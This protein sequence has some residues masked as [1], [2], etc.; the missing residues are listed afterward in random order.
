MEQILNFFKAFIVSFSNFGT[1]FFNTKIFDVGGVSF[2]PYEAL[3]MSGLIVIIGIW[4]VKLF[5]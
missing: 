1:W 4:I 5:I 2:Y 3:L